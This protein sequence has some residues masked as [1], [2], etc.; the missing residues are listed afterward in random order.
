MALILAGLYLVVSL[1]LH[2]VLPGA[3]FRA[4]TWADAGLFVGLVLAVNPLKHRIQT[5]VDRVL[6]GGWYDYQW[7]DIDLPMAIEDL[8]LAFENRQDLPVLFTASGDDPGDSIS[9]KVRTALYRIVQESLHNAWKYAQAEEIEVRLDFRPDRVCLAIRDDGVG[10]EAP[11][12]L[13]GHMGQGRLGLVGMRERAM[14]VGGSFEIASVPG[15][16]TRIRVEI[17]LSARPSKGRLF[18]DRVAVGLPGE[19]RY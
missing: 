1:T 18:A 10:F 2:R 8:V 7:D 4:V 11:A 5:F 6:Y 9:D 16:G 17:P 12:H 19:R 3:S 13:G 15:Q 14:E